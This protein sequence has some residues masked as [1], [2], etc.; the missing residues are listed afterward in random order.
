MSLGPRFFSGSLAPLGSVI[1]SVSPANICQVSF[2]GLGI[3]I[4]SL[5]MLPKAVQ[6]H[7]LDY[8][9]RKIK[10]SSSDDNGKGEEE[11]EPAPS[12]FEQ[13]L[14]AVVAHLQVPHSWFISFYV[15]YLLCSAYWAAQWWSWRQAGP[16]SEVPNNLFGLIVTRQQTSDL[17]LASLPATSMVLAQVYIAFTLEAVQTGRRM[18]EYLCVF[19]PSKAKMNAEHFLM[20]FIYYAIMSVAV[21]VEGSQ[22]IMTAKQHNTKFV[23]ESAF[24]KIVVGTFFFLLAWVG[25]YRCHAHLASLKKYSLPEE[26]LFRY[27]I[28]PHYTCEL[29]MYV[30]LSIVTAPEGRLV[31]R[32]VFSSLL[33]VLANLGV[34][35]DRTKRWYSEKFGA[36]RV[37][38]KWRIIPFVF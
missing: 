18:Y 9:P 6:K 13:A 15:F 14:A 5:T 29:S 8:G 31:N 26:G 4:I 7:V 38:K 33:F 17:V 24:A 28:S 2:V 20:G 30:A 19:K 36:E 37:A 21:W 1:M 32:T 10:R 16:G 35:A 34:T 12:A 25:Q 11:P 22:A 27:L 23:P 3:T